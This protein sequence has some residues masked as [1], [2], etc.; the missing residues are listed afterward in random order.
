MTRPLVALGARMSAAV[1]S[2]HVTGRA[3][4]LSSMA[5]GVA[6]G[7]LWAPCAGPILGLILTGAALQGTTFRTWML[8]LAYAAGAA[9]S[10][11][12][13]LLAGKKVFATLK[14]FLVMERWIR[15]AIGVA[16]LIAVISVALGWD[17]GILTHLSAANT[18]GFEQ[19][20]LRWLRPAKPTQAAGAT[21]ETEDSEPSFEDATT[22]I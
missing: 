8:L 16:V 3:S 17:R 22:W 6:T 4:L 11:A 9:T 20:L 2:S 19:G 15:P 1:D 12:I 14:R 5:L 21:N 10:L 13:A 7:L 18:T